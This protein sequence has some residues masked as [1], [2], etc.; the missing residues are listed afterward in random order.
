MMKHKSIP[1]KWFSV[2]IFY[3]RQRAVLD[4][5]EHLSSKSRW[6]IIVIV[7]NIAYEISNGPVYKQQRYRKELNSRSTLYLFDF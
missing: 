2:A 5:N 1:V 3:Q 4:Q 7:E 6:N